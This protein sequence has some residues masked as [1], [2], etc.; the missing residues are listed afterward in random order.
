M[1]RDLA[2]GDEVAVVD[3]VERA[4]HD[5]DA[6]SRRCAPG[7]P[8][9]RRAE[10]GGAAGSVLLG[11]PIW[12]SVDEVR[13]VDAGGE[14]FATSRKLQHDEAEDGEEQAAATAIR[15]RAGDH[16]REVFV[17]LD[18]E[19]ESSMGSPFRGATPSA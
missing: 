12:W 14:R 16:R 4:T 3:R 10:C 7:V 15:P 17:V 13:C 5:A 11:V 19:G 8:S 2:R 1:L 18:Q 6:G 9:R